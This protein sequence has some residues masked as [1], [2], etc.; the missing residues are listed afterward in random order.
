M[1]LARCTASLIE[2]E[3][4]PIAMWR[5][6]CRAPETQHII[7]MNIPWSLQGTTETTERSKGNRVYR[8]HTSR[9]DAVQD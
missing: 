1:V 2:L 6:A 7:D 3:K 4:E 5:K 9:K 8:R